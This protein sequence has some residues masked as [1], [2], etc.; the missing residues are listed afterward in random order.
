MKLRRFQYS[1]SPDMSGARTNPVLRRDMPMRQPVMRNVS[2]YL[3]DPKA[4]QRDMNLEVAAA[5]RGK[6]L[7]N[8]VSN[9]M[10]QL[11]ETLAQAEAQALGT[12][13]LMDYK[14]EL[15]VATYNAKGIP[16]TRTQ[17][18]LDASSGKAKS[19]EVPTH[20]D[21][22]KTFDKATKGIVESYIGRLP[23]AV[24]NQV[25]AQML[26][27]GAS[28]RDQVVNMAIKK[29]IEYGRHVVLRAVTNAES[30]GDVEGIIN[31]PN[32]QLYLSATE[33]NTIYKEKMGELAIR[34]YAS[35]IVLAAS[36][37]D[38]AR[39]NLA[40]MEERLNTGLIDE[41]VTDE[42]GAVKYTVDDNGNFVALTKPGID[43][44]HRFLSGE[45]I[46]S[47]HSKIKAIGTAMDAASEKARESEVNGVMNDI[48]ATAGD[49]SKASEEVQKRYAEFGN[50]WSDIIKHMVDDGSDSILEGS[51]ITA[52]LARI[53]AARDGDI[54]QPVIYGDVLEN[55]EQYATKDGRDEIGKMQ[56]LTMKQIQDLKARSRK[57]ERA[58]ENW[59]EK[60]NPFNNRGHIAVT[61]LKG[62]FGIV[63]TP[64]SGVFA[65]F[66]TKEKASAVHQA[67]QTLLRELHDHVDG[68]DD[69]RL[70]P[71]EALKWVY[72]KIDEDNLAGRPLA[73]GG[74]AKKTA[75]TPSAS[76]DDSPEITNTQPGV[77]QTTA[78]SDAEKEFH[79]TPGSKDKS[80]NVYT[81]AKVAE[82]PPGPKRNALVEVM[83]EHGHNVV[84]V[85]VAT[86]SGEKETPNPLRPVGWGITIWPPSMLPTTPWLDP[87]WGR[88]K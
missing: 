4:G 61:A 31:S 21:L 24:R 32:A 72:E 59:W 63:E 16:L 10:M 57:M 67:Y 70:K 33:L 48:T 3:R 73:T 64:D 84:P 25:R 12:D 20:N 36:S 75:E 27:L 83:K 17:T 81:A 47:M 56:G 80:G 71:G 76:T 9:G 29:R 77:R 30:P 55:L 45:N 46:L 54:A 23:L 13:A 2:N 28:A 44:L 6:H 5:G 43:P 8:A 78:Q 60:D 82:M 88:S 37:G 14:K 50:N 68:I 19:R 38:A 62:H 65:K 35:K 11:G 42:S 51:D 7:A 39:G 40:V 18:Y 34:D 74:K 1:T 26:S 52:L 41:K 79:K 66:S 86:E 15:A 85:V 22:I 58:G 49:F 53:K 87:A 69:V